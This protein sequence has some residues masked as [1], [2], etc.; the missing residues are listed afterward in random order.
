MHQVFFQEIN[1]ALQPDYP[2]GRDICA[3]SGDFPEE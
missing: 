1:A 3:A 2:T